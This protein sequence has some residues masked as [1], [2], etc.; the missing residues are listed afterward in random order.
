VSKAYEMIS[1]YYGDER[2]KR[3]GVP[4]INHINEGMAVLDYIGANDVTIDAY[5]I[6]PILQS[7]MDFKINK[8]LDFDGIPTEAL[9]LACEYRHVA[10]SYLSK[11]EISDFI[12]FTCKEVR[13]MLIADKI[14]NYKDFMLYHY[15]THERSD[16]LYSYFHNWFSDLLKIDE[17]QILEICFGYVENK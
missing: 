10:N 4:L 13:Q 8:T 1:K 5:C 14:Q 15:G 17:E 6:H 7:D 11:D 3:S 12:G 2:A 9:L 16:A